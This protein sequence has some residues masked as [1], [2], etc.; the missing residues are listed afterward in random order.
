MIQSKLLIL[1]GNL[2]HSKQGDIYILYI[3]FLL[4]AFSLT[5]NYYSSTKE[6]VNNMIYFLTHTGIKYGK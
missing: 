2:H 1:V 6:I 4:L 5:F 3:F